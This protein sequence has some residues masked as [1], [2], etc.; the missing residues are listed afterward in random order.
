MAVIK[1]IF[2]NIKSKKVLVNENSKS[3]TLL[4]NLF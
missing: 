1:G 3:P 4:A 2:T